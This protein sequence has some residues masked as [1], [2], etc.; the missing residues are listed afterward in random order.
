[1]NGNKTH[2]GRDGIRRKFV[3]M[4]LQL[5]QVENAVR[6]SLPALGFSSRESM[7]TPPPPPP[8]SRF[9]TLEAP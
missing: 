6:L 1:M 5:L 8:L 3:A 2:G 4:K 9:Y 7:P